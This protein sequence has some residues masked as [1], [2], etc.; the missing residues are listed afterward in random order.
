MKYN[1]EIH[2]R[3]SIRLKNYDY[4][5]NGLYFVTMCC[6]H[7]QHLF[8]EIVLD[9]MKLNIAG[10]MIFKTWLEL[11]KLFDC[12]NL[13]EFVIMPN[14]FHGIIEIKG[15]AQPQRIAPT[16]PEIVGV[17]LV[18]IQ[19]VDIQNNNNLGS[20]LGAF[21]SIT[22]NKYIKMVKEN[23]LPVFEKR[24]WQRN[25]HEH[26]VR[27]DKDLT[28]IQEYIVNNPLSWSIDTLNSQENKGNHEELPQRKPSTKP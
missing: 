21:K 15:Q 27:N 26:I 7:R 13:H 10:E 12:I 3:R 17:P 5:T 1:P 16:K 14:H 9:E 22:T 8:G 18:G 24:I 28:R 11:P 2:H 4:S 23:I 6:E 20:V 19:N 25:Y